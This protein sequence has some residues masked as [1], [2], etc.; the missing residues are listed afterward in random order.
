MSRISI[1]LSGD[2]GSG[3]TH[4][5][6]TIVEAGRELFVLATEPGVV[7]ILGDLPIEKCH[8][9]YISPAVAS[10]D[11][12]RECA[13]QANS[14]SMDA[15]QKATSPQKDKF[16]QYIDVLNL[17]CN[18]TD[19]R[20][21]ETFGAVDE[22]P[23][24]VFFAIDNCSGICDMSMA[25]VTGMKFAT[26]QPEWGASQ[27]AALAL[28]NKLCSDL[29]CN[30]VLLAHVEKQIDE[31]TGGTHTTLA[32]LGNKLSPKIIKPFDEVIAS[33]REKDEFRWSTTEYNMTLKTRLLGWGDKHPPSF[34][35]LIKKLEESPDFKS[36][37]EMDEAAE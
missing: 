4:S 35:P 30:F 23:Q 26:T 14:F 25:L 1:C 19:Y 12:L 31:L 29:K 15:L 10:W 7:N 3:K 37:V 34:A 11:V 36:L 27:R 33:I 8:I 24:E 13:I 16:R 20:T 18:F 28:M 21:G 32:S 17:L 2:V 5:L 6:R 9:A 22:L